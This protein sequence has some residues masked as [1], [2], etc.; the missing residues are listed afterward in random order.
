MEIMG[1]VHIPSAAQREG[2]A[3]EIIHSFGPFVSRE[4]PAAKDP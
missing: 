1:R 4:T 2:V 3:M